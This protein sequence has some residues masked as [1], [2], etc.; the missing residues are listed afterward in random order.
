VRDFAKAM[1][2][3]AKTDKIDAHVIARFADSVRPEIRPLKT[4]ETE[5]LD[6][7]NTRRSQLIIML[8]AEKN[9]LTTAS[10]WTKKDVEKAL[11][12][13][14][15]HLPKSTVRLK[16]LSKKARI[17]GIWTRSC[18]VFPV[19]AC[20]VIDHPCRSAGDWNN[21]PKADS[22]PCWVAPLNRDSGKYK[23]RRAIWGGRARIRSVLYMCV[24]SAFV[25]T[26]R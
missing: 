11:K 17:G 2:V 8:T 22:G 3:L 9:R 6:A 25:T 20:Y 14:K 15:R 24:I 19:W 7:F 12:G 16:I 18:K 23:G 4:E 1:G 21:E 13:W 10:K 5:I 26:P